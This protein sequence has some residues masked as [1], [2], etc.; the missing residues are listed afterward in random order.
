VGGFSYADVL[1]SA[2][3]WAGTIRFNER[4]LKQFQQF[5][6]RWALADCLTVLCFMSVR[7]A[8]AACFLQRARAQAV[9]AVIQQVGDLKNSV[10]V[11]LAT[12]LRQVQNVVGLSWRTI[13][14]SNNR[15]VLVIDSEF[16]LVRVRAA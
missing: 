2:K 9:P 4:V 11:R 15:W 10:L 14:S 13:T 8:A 16:C 6:N 5:Y 3:G 1:D 12:A 7:T